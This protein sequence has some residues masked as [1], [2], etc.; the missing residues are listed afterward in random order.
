MSPTGNLRQT[1]DRLDT[2]PA[3]PHI[4]QKILSLKIT[5]DKGE[6]ELFQLIEQDPSILSKIIGLSNSPLFGTGRNI[7]TLQDATALLG[8]RRIKMIALSFSMMSSIS[9]K[10]SGLLNVQNLWQHSMTI[11]MVMDTLSGYMP[12]ELRPS[13]D[14]IYLAGLL[15]D[16]GFLVLDHIDTQISD[17]FHARLAAE[18]GCTVAEIESEML[19]MNHCELGAELGRHWSLPETIVIVLSYHH[20][21]NNKRAA[22]GWPLVGMTNLAE[23]LLPAFGITEPV[24]PEIEADEWRALG[25]DPSRENEIV[26]TVEKFVR[27]VSSMFA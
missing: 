12:K 22:T 9:K 10:Q 6:Q 15:H 25:I 13:E 7:L 2:L 3:I 19:E 23:K 27:E 18:P 21:P 14:E 11:A 16:I 26:A 17:R 4:A 5:T 20:T 24:H 8:N 1:L